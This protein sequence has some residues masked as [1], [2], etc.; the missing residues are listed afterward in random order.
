MVCILQSI[1]RLLQD[2]CFKLCVL[3]WEDWGPE[4]RQAAAI[5]LGLTGHAKVG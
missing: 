4:V 1:L 5:A 3:S 2:L